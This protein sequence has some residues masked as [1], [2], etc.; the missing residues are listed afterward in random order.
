VR[1]FAASLQSELDGL[2]RADRLRVC[3]PLSGPSRQRPTL[4]PTELVSFCSND[5]LGLAHHPALIQAAAAAAEREGF[6]AGSARLVAGDLPAHRALEADLASF[7]K[8]EA[9]LLFPTGYQANLGTLAALAGSDDLI[10]SDAANHASLI[11]GCRLSKATVSIYPH[12][13]A[14]AARAA[15]STPGSFRRRFLVT[16]SLF[17]MDGDVPPLAALAA[18]AEAADAVFIVDEAHALGVSGPGGEGFCAAAGIVPDVL[19]GTLGKALGAA[20]GFV[21]GAEVL[22]SYLLNRARTFVF[23]TAAPPPIAAAAAAALRILRGPEGDARRARLA[24]HRAHLF[25]RLRGR[26]SPPPGPIVPVI[27]GV[28]AAALGAS[29]ALRERGLFVSAIRPPT[30]PEGTARLRITLSSQHTT[31]EIDRLCAALL[32]IL[33]A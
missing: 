19:I 29:T 22:R 9:A 13:D 32:E 23:T 14:A 27:F 5:Y 11:D 1:D 31:D 3:P 28:D 16:E 20:G 18:A 24:S 12:A 6:G 33:P 25:E 17:S 8:R 4:G 21:A 15:L 10:A 2:A 7:L 30:V 26:I